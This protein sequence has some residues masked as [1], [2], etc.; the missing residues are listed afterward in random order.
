MAVVGRALLILGLAVCA[1]GIGASIYG[2]VRGE[3][4]FIVSG[5]RAVYALAAPSV[6]AA[7]RAASEVL[8]TSSTPSRWRRS[9]LTAP[10]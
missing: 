3:E 1:Y 9:T 5:R 6:P 10:R 4:R 7:I 2:A 8:S